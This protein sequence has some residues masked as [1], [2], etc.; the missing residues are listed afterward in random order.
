MTGRNRGRSIDLIFIDEAADI[1]F[2]D[3]EKFMKV[4]T[5]DRAGQDKNNL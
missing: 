4:I 3:I 2:E 1:C 5:H